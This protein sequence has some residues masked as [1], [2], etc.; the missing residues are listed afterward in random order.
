MDT[1]VYTATHLQIRIA[2]VYQYRSPLGT[3]CGRVQALIIRSS[4]SFEWKF[5]ASASAELSVRPVEKVR[6]VRTGAETG[7][8]WE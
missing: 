3:E 8:L 4:G 1:R 5:S 2:C 6:Y 7:E